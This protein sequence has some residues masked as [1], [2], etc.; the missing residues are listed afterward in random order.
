MKKI[1][2]I[3]ISLLIANSAFAL[4]TPMKKLSLYLL[5]LIKHPETRG[6]IHEKMV[7]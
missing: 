4:E 5:Q 1:F 7:P 6:G 2:I 3:I